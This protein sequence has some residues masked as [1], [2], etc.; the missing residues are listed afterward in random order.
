[1]LDK[2]E[3]SPATITV[4]TGKSQS[5]T[6]KAIDTKGA[7]IAVATFTWTMTGAVGTLTPNGATADLLTTSAGAATVEVKVDYGPDSRSAQSS[8]TVQDTAAPPLANVVLTPS[9]VTANVGDKVKV[10]ARALDAQ[11]VEMSGVTFDWTLKGG[12]G[13]LDSSSGDEVVLAVE[14]AGGGSLE[15]TASKDGK[16]ATAKAPVTVK[17][18]FVFPWDL[19]FLLV[20]IIAAAI[21]AAALFAWYRRKKRDE[22]R[23]HQEWLQTRYEQMQQGPQWQQQQWG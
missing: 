16:T 22:Q 1:V 12:V 15:V 4:V 5:F 10:K 3:I 20:G 9:S 13:T 18:P 11:G 14:Q 23:R 8:V 2:A 7:V 19:L 6:A 17:K 21:V